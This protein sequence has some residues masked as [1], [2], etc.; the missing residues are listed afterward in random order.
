MAIL[1]HVNAIPHLHQAQH[2]YHLRL[3]HHP[4]HQVVLILKAAHYHLQQEVL[5]HHHQQVQVRQLVL[6]F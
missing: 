1:V 2:R 6:M 4:H 5:A 3:R